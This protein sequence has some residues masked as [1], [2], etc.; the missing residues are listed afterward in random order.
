MKLIVAHK[1][2]MDGLAAAA[3]MAKLY[4]KNNQPYKVHFQNYGD[5]VEPIT[6]SSCDDLVFVDF[7][8][9]R[10]QM[11]DI[12]SSFT[13]ILVLDH[14]KTAETALAGIETDIP[15]ID[16]I[17]D[18]GKS[19]AMI[20]AD[21]YEMIECER[22][23]KCD[24]ISYISD[25]D[26]W[27]WELPGSHEINEGLRALVDLNDIESFNKVVD[28]YMSDSTYIKQVGMI[29]IDK[30]DKEVA[31]AINKVHSIYL[32]GELFMGT[33][34]TAYISEIGNAICHK[35]ELPS[36]TYTI[37]GCGTKVWWSLRSLD[38][39]PDV[40]LTA[41]ALG[42]GGHRNACGFETSIEE[43]PQ[44]LNPTKKTCSCL[45]KA[46]AGLGKKA[47]GVKS[48]ANYADYSTQINF[49][50]GFIR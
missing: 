48:P 13:T 42:G 45:L 36:A 28:Q 31:K 50:K 21:Y 16:V 3:I 4:E 43:L 29:L 5:S 30:K 19:G 11:I 10:E 9:P 20:A 22:P 18:M 41:K 27:K 7:S 14:H 38:N 46:I 26:L 17:F 49:L 23:Y 33:N 32:N 40:S 24:I 34:T 2:C 12:A 15:H 25:R 1:N 35:Y 37:S 8:L 47:A 39:L 44:I 6:D